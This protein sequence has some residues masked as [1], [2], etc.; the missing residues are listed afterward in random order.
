MSSINQDPPGGTDQASQ[1][2]HGPDDITT[3]HFE[4]EVNSGHF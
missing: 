3:V 2:V 1:T 4:S